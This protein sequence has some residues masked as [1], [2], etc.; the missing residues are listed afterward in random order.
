MVSSRECLGNAFYAICDVGPTAIHIPPPHPSPN[1]STTSHFQL[2]T[3][4]RP[5]PH[6]PTSSEARPG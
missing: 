1:P 6:N 3:T 5:R 4:R 2:P